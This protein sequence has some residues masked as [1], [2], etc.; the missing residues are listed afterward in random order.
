ME[1]SVNNPQTEVKNKIQELC[2]K[3]SDSVQN[4]CFD[5]K[6]LCIALLQAYDAYDK[7]KIQELLKPSSQPEPDNFL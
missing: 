1:N 4:N 6:L 2:N 7:I 3:I 5:V